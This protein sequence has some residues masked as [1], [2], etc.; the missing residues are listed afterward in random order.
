MLNQ[1]NHWI[2]YA[3]AGIDLV[4]LLRVLTLRLQRTYVFLT[5]ACALAVIFDVAS[6][7]YAEEQ[8]PRVWIYSELFSALI[9]PLAVWDIFEEIASSVAA[10]RRLAIMRTLASLIII[11]FFGL[12]WLTSV[13]QSDDPTGLSFLFALTLIVSTGSAAGCLGFLWIMHRGLTLQK[14][15]TPKNTTVWMIFYALLMVGQIA[16]WLVLIAEETIS[17]PARDTFSPIANLV[18]NFFGMVITVWCAFRLRGLPK[19]IPSPV[20]ETEPPSK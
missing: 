5:L 6:L 8:F 13:S 16:S 14:I 1:I 15:L 9:F 12:L 17:Q 19:D 20:S 4:L 3:A 10:L 18:L 11:S 7:L 2:E